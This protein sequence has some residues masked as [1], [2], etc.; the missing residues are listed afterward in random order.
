MLSIVTLILVILV[1]ACSIYIVY[2]GAKAS[3]DPNHPFGQLEFAVSSMALLGCAI[4]ISYFAIVY[5]V[6][7]E[8]PD[9]TQSS[10][11]PYTPSY[12]YAYKYARLKT[13]CKGNTRSYSKPKFKTHKG[14]P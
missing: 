8:E 9:V 14:R 6:I 11:R 12:T 5:I 10:L 1:M 4:L 13:S 3:Q 2:I 7:P